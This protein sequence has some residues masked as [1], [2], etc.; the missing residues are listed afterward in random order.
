MDELIIKEV[1]YY[2]GQ[3][4]AT[5]QDVAELFNR[6]LSS[7]KKDFAKF[8]RE[9]ET[10]PESPYYK[11]YLAEK[12]KSSESEHAGKIKG[13]LD[14]KGGKSRVLTLKETVKVARYIVTSG[15][16]LDKAS[17]VFKIP[18]STLYE[19]IERLNEYFDDDIKKLYGM[20]RNIYDANKNRISSTPIDI[21]TFD[22]K[23]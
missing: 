15:C 8:R 22:K 14:S 11:L 1:K 13:G 6:S 10:N 18:K 4:N 23:I 20:V 21:G 7:V 19:S 17:D 3:P 12:E 5:K 2:V 16:T 9:V